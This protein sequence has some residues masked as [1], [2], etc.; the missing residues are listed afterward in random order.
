MVVESVRT[1]KGKQ[2]TNIKLTGQLGDVLKESAQIALSWIHSNLSKL[3][4][5]GDN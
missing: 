4:L 1:G 3:Q 2:Q 5:K